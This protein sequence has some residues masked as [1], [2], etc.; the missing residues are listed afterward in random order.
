MISFLTALGSGM[1]LPQPR[2]FESMVSVNIL[3]D[4]IITVLGG[5]GEGCFRGRY[6][7][8]DERSIRESV[9]VIIAASVLL[10]IP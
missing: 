3:I 2:A 5:R 4:F 1:S 7:T 10:Q 9:R 8:L 6:E